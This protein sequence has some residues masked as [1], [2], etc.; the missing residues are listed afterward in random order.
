MPFLH[1]PDLKISLPRLL[2]ISMLICPSPTG[3]SFLMASLLEAG[4]MLRSSDVAQPGVDA[5]GHISSLAAGCMLTNRTFFSRCTV[6]S[7]LIFSLTAPSQW[8]LHSAQVWSLGTSLCTPT[9]RGWKKLLNGCNLPSL[10]TELSHRS[11][12]HRRLTGTHSLFQW[13]NKEAFLSL[14]SSLHRSVTPLSKV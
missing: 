8:S 12:L 3:L 11:L 5:N 7:S 2:R 13:K 1:T 10:D 6:L 9:F 14:S 4:P